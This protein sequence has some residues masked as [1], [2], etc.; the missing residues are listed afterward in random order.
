VTIDDSIRVL[1]V[2]DDEPHS[3]VLR[4]ALAAA[5][6][7]I[8]MEH[9]RTL[10]EAIAHLE[11]PKFDAVLLNLD[12]PDSQG[13]QT[14]DRALAEIP[15]LP[16]V[17]ITAAE[18][19]DLGVA[20]VQHGAQD[21]LARARTIPDISRASLRFAVERAGFQDGI[22]SPRAAL[23]RLIEHAHDMVVLIAPDGVILYQSPATQ[24]ILGYPPEE[25][26]G[27]MCST[28]FI[29]STDRE[30]SSCWPRGLPFSTTTNRS[31]RSG[32]ATRT[33]RGVRLKRS[34]RTSA[35]TRGWSGHQCP[36]CHRA[37]PGAGGAA[38]NRSEAAAGAEDGRGRTA[39][40][41]HCPR[42]QQHPHRDLRY[43]DL[44]LSDLDPDDRRRSDVQEIRLMAQ[45]AANL[46]RQL[47][48]FSRQQMLQPQVL[49]LNVV[50]GDMRNMLERM[51]APTCR[52]R[53][54]PPRTCG[55][56]VR[57]ADRSS[58]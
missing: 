5:R 9:C 4:D 16:I 56:C 7:P 37:S 21:Y 28:S 32:S 30:P 45:R 14:I 13:L 3:V 20:A 17:V 38:G 25:L 15:G 58:R 34:G 31:C 50:I 18:E 11:Q 12:L 54:S 6:P 47:L 8:E 40:R 52:C 33:A 55:R 2:E 10:R 48:A 27:P 24:R 23:P 49:D 29:R 19:S 57:T 44:L 41:R 35:L 26:A 43:A 36:G 42:L 53:S 39:G 51:M 1:L 22:G 46:T